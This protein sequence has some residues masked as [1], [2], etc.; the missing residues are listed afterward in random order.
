MGI[1]MTPRPED[2]QRILRSLQEYSRRFGTAIAVENNVGVIRI[3]QAPSHR[4]L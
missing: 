3:A 4:R 2:A 1:P